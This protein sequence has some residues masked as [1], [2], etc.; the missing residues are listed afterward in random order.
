MD[1]EFSAEQ[2]AIRDTIRELVQD[3]VAPRAADIDAKAEYT[4]DI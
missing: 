3:K 2:L 4:K 1:F